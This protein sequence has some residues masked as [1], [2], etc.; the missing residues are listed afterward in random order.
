MWWSNGASSRHHVSVAGA[1]KRIW[2]WLWDQLA[3]VTLQQLAATIVEKPTIKHTSPLKRDR[4]KEPTQ[5]VSPI[6]AE[7]TSSA[8]TQ[9]IRVTVQSQYLPHQSSPED[10][11]FVFA[12][13]VVISNESDTEA[14]LRTR[15]W[16]ITDGNGHVEEVKGPGVV[17]ET[18]KLAPGESFR[19]TSGCVL[20]TE[21]GT[22]HGTYQMYRKDG[23]HFDAVIAP[24]TLASPIRMSNQLPN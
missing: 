1:T 18:P 7:P 8:N 5:H 11:R 12:Y 6:V 14:Q 15:H 21:V 19:Y 24:F 20:R 13:T 22:M 4:P 17:G 16:I 10:G 3:Q 23:S 2:R 9:G